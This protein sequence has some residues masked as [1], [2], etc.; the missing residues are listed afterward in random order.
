M[1]SST[2]KIIHA[3]TKPQTSI[4]PPPATNRNNHL[5]SNQTLNPLVMETEM[6]KKYINIK[7]KREFPIEV[8]KFPF[9]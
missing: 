5:L 1:V 9:I 8:V 3:T 7:G 2:K 4:T 6:G